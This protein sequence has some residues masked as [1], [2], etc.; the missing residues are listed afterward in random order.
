M[1]IQATY[2]IWCDT[3]SKW[4]YV[5]QDIDAAVPTVCPT[6]GGHTVDTD[7]TAITETNEADVYRNVGKE[8]EFSWADNSERANSADYSIISRFGFDGSDNIGT[9]IA[10]KMLSHMGSATDYRIRLYDITN[11]LVICESAVLTNTDPELKDCGTVSNIPTTP[12]VWELQGKR[13]SGSW[14]EV[15]AMS[16]KF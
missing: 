14:C 6:D 4:E 10:V 9:P 3:D 8:M 12:A 15:D 11:S 16:I 5:T 7:K 2:R 13:T 1:A